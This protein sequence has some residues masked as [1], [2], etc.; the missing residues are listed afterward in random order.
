MFC[1]RENKRPLEDGLRVE[2]EALRG[3]IAGDVVLTQGF[4]DIRFDD[5]RVITDSFFA[6][7]SN[8]RMGVINF[9]NRRACKS[10]V[11]GKLTLQ[12]RFAKIDICQ[13]AVERIL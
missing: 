7:F 3:P 13:D 5:G 4:G 8:E 6:S 1:L 2:G 12:N 11:F 10:G 9:L